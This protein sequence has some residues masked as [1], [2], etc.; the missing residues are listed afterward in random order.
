MKLHYEQCTAFSQESE[1]AEILTTV[2]LSG[3]QHLQIS[4]SLKLSRTLWCPGAQ[5][6]EAEEES[7]NQAT[8]ANLLLFP[9]PTR[10]R[11][12]ALGPRFGLQEGRGQQGLK[13]VP[14]KWCP[15]S[16]VVSH[17]CPKYTVLFCVWAGFGRL[18][19]LARVPCLLPT[20]RTLRD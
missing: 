5:S 14:R 1:R 9:S 7:Q 10:G 17:S 19:S 4:F 18:Q 3:R 16:A 12:W 2:Y 8:L 15:T 13:A 11:E 20:K 6:G